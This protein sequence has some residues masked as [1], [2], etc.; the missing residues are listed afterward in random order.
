M[1]VVCCVVQTKRD[2]GGY[3]QLRP[4]SSQVSA[5]AKRRRPAR[6]REVR[7]D[8]ST[9]AHLNRQMATV[10]DV[11]QVSGFVAALWAAGGLADRLRC[12]ALIGELLAGMALRPKS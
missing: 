7:A 4:K 3:A 6:A 5:P 10:A 9:K 8:S 2:S 1:S 12:P 11:L